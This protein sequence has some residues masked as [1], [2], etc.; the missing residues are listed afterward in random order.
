MSAASKVYFPKRFYSGRHNRL[1]LFSISNFFGDFHYQMGICKSLCN[2]RQSTCIEIYKNPVPSWQ[3]R[4]LWQF[5]TVERFYR[6]KL[7][8]N[9]TFHFGKTVISQTIVILTVIA[10]W[11]NGYI[12]NIYIFNR[13]F[14]Q[15]ITVLS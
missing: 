2:T 15:N 11:Q 3:S 4:G 6:R 12:V 5:L 9:G 10:R 14:S 8:F 7:K 13:N 1:L